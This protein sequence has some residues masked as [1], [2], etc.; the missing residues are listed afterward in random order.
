MNKVS[1][2]TEVI[3]K[4]MGY[5][6]EDHKGN[7]HQA[8]FFDIAN[9]YLR[10][11]NEYKGQFKEYI[12]VKNPSDVKQIKQNSVSW[13]CNAS[14]GHGKTTVLISFL[15]W[16]V[17]ESEKFKVPVLVAVR[18]NNMADEIYS[19]LRDFDKNCVLRIDKDNKHEAGQY[20][21]YYQI[22]IITH[23][24]LKRLAL[25]YEN[26]QEYRLFQQYSMDLFTEESPVIEELITNRWNRL[27]IIDEKPDFI[28]NSIFDL[29][30]EHNAVEWFDRLS[31]CLEF[32]SY[33]SQSIKSLIIH[34]IANELAEN[35]GTISMALV[36]KNERNTKRILNLIATLAQIEE[37]AVGYDVLDMEKLKAFKKMLFRNEV[38]RIDEYQDRNKVGRKI[39]YAERVDYTKLGLNTL[40]LDGTCQLNKKQYKDFEFMPI[41]NYNDYSRLTITQDIINTSNWSRSKKG[42]PTQKAIGIRVGEL[43]NQHENLFLLPLK[44]DLDTY[45]KLGTISPEFATQYFG[46]NDTEESS[47]LNLLNTTGKNQL[48]DVTELYLPSLPRRNPDHYKAIAISLYG[49]EVDLSINNETDDY[50]WF[51]D[52]K[53]ERIYRGEL[54]AEILQIIHRTALRKIQDENEIRIFL[55]FDDTKHNPVLEEAQILLS[56]IN[57]NYMG[58]QAQLD[59]YHVQDETLY[60]IGERIRQFAEDIDN[61]VKKNTTFFNSSTFKLSEVDKKSGLGEEFRKWLSKN[62]H[63]EKD[64]GIID[65]IF[66]EF[67]YVIYSD[68]FD[69][70]GTKMITTIANYERLIGNKY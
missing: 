43:K 19:E 1:D 60:G 15:K 10:F 20:I 12:G 34:L 53:L 47:P 7:I 22:V 8:A 67:G 38:A 2:N 13:V 23:A 17:S 66:R 25:G 59:T 54:Y 68:P 48:R 28:N 4:M 41:K 35:T 39:H 52:E 24:R 56:E 46:K 11:V 14:M 3:E 29:G 27:L 63:W 69:K 50:N 33:K 65:R 6:S 26:A 51:K 36:P 45:I 70:R 37:K 49:K 21:P 31:G 44:S 16:L 57:G 9:I 62:N 64:R 42:Q 18:E 30:K 55:A 61:W 32:D 40:I 58:G 5:L